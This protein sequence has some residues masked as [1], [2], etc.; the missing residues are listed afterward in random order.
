MRKL[1]IYDESCPMC[2]LYTKGMVAVNSS[3]DLIRISNAQL[4]QETIN[5]LDTQRARHEIP[6]VDLDGGE[7]IYGVDTWTYAFSNW[8]KS[9]G[10]LLSLKPLRALFK[11]LYA[12]ISYNRRIIITSAPGRWNLLDLQPDFHAGYRIAFILVVFGIISGLFATVSLPIW[13]PAVLALVV[14]QLT[15]ACLY[16]LRQH[17]DSFLQRMLDYTGHLG[18]SLLLGGAI[19]AI[20]IV[21]GY[22]A[23]IPIAYALTLGQHFIRTY[24]LGLN[25]WLSV[26]FTALVLLLIF[27]Y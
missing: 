27:P 25:P 8:N 11:K 6:L 3:G 10:K 5:R 2:R 12:F 24:R 23:L 4:T 18:M 19:S 22:T 14:V 9:V 1:I 7:T 13:P 16:L 17:T 15:I 20:G 26:C 21:A